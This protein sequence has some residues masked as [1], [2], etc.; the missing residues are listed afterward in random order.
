MCRP[1]EQ[2][3]SASAEPAAAAGGKPGGKG[4]KKGQSKEAGGRLEF[5]HTLNATACAVPRM[6]VA[7]LENFQQE[8]GSVVVPE[9]LRPYLGGMA[10]IA[11]P[12]KH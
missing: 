5:V 1:A 7:I 9:P 3:G 8:D 4:G 12:T 6:I 2:P 11:A 10:V